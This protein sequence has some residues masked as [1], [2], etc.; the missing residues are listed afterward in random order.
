L[1]IIR[2]EGRISFLF[3]AYTYD[4]KP[5]TLRMK[6]RREEWGTRKVKTTFKSGS[7]GRIAYATYFAWVDW[8]SFSRKY[9]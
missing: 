7:T 3:E 4:T 5:P 6:Q 2:W 1:S 8:A 9:S